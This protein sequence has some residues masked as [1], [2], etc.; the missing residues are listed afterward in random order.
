MSDTVTFTSGVHVG[1]RGA[2]SIN[3]GWFAGSPTT[4]F[5]TFSLDLADARGLESIIN[6]PEHPAPVSLRFAGAGL[7]QALATLRA[8]EAQD[9]LN[10]PRRTLSGYTDVVARTG[11]LCQLAV[12]LYGDEEARTG[13]GVLTDVQSAVEFS[14]RNWSITARF[15]PVALLGWTGT[16]SMFIHPT[17]YADLPAAS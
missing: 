6:T 13:W 2:G 4:Q 11:F 9:V 17:A 12:Q 10:G 16:E 3:Q 7:A 8:I 1:T 14:Q 5:S 15:F